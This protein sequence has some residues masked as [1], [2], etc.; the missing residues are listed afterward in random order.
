MLRRLPLRL[1]RRT[2]WR[3]RLNE[4]DRQHAVHDL[5]QCDNILRGECD[6]RD[7]IGA[8]PVARDITLGKTRCRRRS[9]A[10]AA[11]DGGAKRSSPPVP[12]LPR[13]GR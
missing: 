6:Q 2:R 1:L 5:L 10:G 8:R 11:R 12:A 9:A 13:D 3:G 7:E 4:P